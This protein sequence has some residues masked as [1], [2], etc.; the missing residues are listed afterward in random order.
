MFTWQFQMPCVPL[1]F[2]IHRLSITYCMRVGSCCWCK[3]QQNNPKAEERGDCCILVG[4]GD[5]Q[6]GEMGHSAGRVQWS[7]DKMMS[8]WAHRALAL[9]VLRAGSRS[10]SES[11]SLSPLT[12]STE[13]QSA[14]WHSSPPDCCCLTVCLGAFFGSLCGRL[15]MLGSLAHTRCHLNGERR[16]YRNSFC[17]HGCISLFMFC[18]RM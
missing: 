17:V 16:T 13:L 15:A 12:V 2:D 1:Q 8:S 18:E 4:G 5:G 14:A 10:L 7:F 9:L 3:K 6:D 11:P